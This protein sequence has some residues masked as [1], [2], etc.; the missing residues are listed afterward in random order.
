MSEVEGLLK[1]EIALN[2]RQIKEMREAE[3]KEV[4]DIGR[5]YAEMK[6]TNGWQRLE[7]EIYG[8]V[9]ALTS[10]LHSQEGN[11]LYRAQGESLGIQSILSIVNSAIEDGEQAKNE[12]IEQ[13]E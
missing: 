9:A 12:K 13:E 5:E 8:R 1:E 4:V 7:K 3:L 2:A 10:R 11:P 6:K